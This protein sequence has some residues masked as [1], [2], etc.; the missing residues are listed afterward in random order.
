MEPKNSSILQHVSSIAL[1]TAPPELVAAAFAA[2]SM[3]AL[4]QHFGTTVTP[5]IIQRHSCAAGGLLVWEADQRILPGYGPLHGPLDRAVIKAGFVGAHMGMVLQNRCCNIGFSRRAIMRRDQLSAQ[6]MR[7]GVR[8]DRAPFEYK[9][10]AEDLRALQVLLTGCA[11]LILT[12]AAALITVAIHMADGR[13]ACVAGQT[14]VHCG[15]S[16]QAEDSQT[17]TVL[18]KP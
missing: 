1:A 13:E 10:T 3:A 9:R 16:S 15:A 14:S 2:A 6:Y 5:A 4:A 7:Y 18:D 11:D 17:R 12:R 8:P